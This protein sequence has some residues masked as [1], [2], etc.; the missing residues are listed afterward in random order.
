MPR[1]MTLALAG[2]VMLG[3][4]VNRAIA[5]R[6]SAYPWGDV[7]PLLR[8][9]DLFLINLECALTALNQPW[10]DGAY[11]AFYF[12]ADPAVVTTLQHAR[13]AFASLANNHTGDF[14]MDGLVETLQVL[15]R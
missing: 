10:H 7:L 15:D 9:A 5:T 3:R 12:R 13:V 4:Q 1:P 2:D 11:K 6:G 14:G 8:Q